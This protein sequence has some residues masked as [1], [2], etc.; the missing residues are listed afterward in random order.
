MTNNI[1]KNYIIIAMVFILM[2][3]IYYAN[4]FKKHSELFESGRNIVRPN[5][6]NIDDLNT[7]QLKNIINE[8]NE[9]IQRHIAKIDKDKNKYTDPVIGP[10]ENID[11]YFKKIREVNDQYIN[12]N[13]REAVEERD[14][15]EYKPQIVKRYLEDPLMRGYNIQE[16]EQY[17]KLLE[18][19]NIEID[20][21]ITPPNPSY[22]SININK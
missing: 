19:G 14:E 11:G 12:D 22:W 18:I 16:S 3:L 17:S 8:Q 2:L 15:S 10:N 13:K 5:F 1:S 6:D 4:T 7:K 9:I 21:K 20:D